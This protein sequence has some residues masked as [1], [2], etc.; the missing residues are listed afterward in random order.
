MAYT[1]V[2]DSC[3]KVFNNEEDFLDCILG[4]SKQGI[5]FTVKVAKNNWQKIAKQINRFWVNSKISIKISSHSDPKAMQIFANALAG[6]M[7][8][9]TI[10]SVAGVGGVALGKFLLTRAAKRGILLAVP[11]G[12]LLAPAL[13]VSDVI[14]VYGLLAGALVGGTFGAAAGVA[15]SYWEINIQIDINNN[16]NLEMHFQPAT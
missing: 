11:G 12:E 2:I 9:G 3:S 10:G 7:V 4:L 15:L 6:S 16:D 8:G 14:Y 5:A 13:L 1:V